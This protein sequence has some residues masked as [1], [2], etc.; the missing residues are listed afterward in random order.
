MRTNILSLPLSAFF[1]S[2][3]AC[4]SPNPNSAFGAGE[5][6]SG[7]PGAATLPLPILSPLV[8]GKLDVDDM[9]RLPLPSV[10]ISVLLRGTS[11]SG[12]RS[13]EVG[14][15]VRFTLCVDEGE[16]EVWTAASGS[17]VGRRSGR[18]MAT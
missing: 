15:C 5:G 9:A 12:A 18:V 14:L 7:T 11:E 6:T 16:E 2:S 4:R 17:A 8:L 13:G 1:S 10:V 3:S